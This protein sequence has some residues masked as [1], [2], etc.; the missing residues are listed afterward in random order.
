MSIILDGSTGIT[1]P[2]IVSPTQTIST[3]LDLTGGQIKFPAT[4]VASSDA[5]TLDD[6]EEGTWTPN[7]CGRTTAGT[8]TYNY[9]VLGQ[10]VKIGNV[11]H[12]L[13]YL[14]VSNATGTGQAVIRGLPFTGYSRLQVVAAWQISTT[15]GQMFADQGGSELGLL[16]IANGNISN[17]SVD[18]TISMQFYFSYFVS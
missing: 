13:G 10:Y 12:V 9:P 18:P 4:Q 15:G 2:N 11:V 14:D 5:N 17:Y 3:K 1:T 6:Y 16:T 7:Y 8:T